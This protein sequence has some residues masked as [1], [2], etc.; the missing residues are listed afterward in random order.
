MPNGAVYVT[1]TRTETLH[2]NIGAAFTVTG[3]AFT[4]TPVVIT[5]RDADKDGDE[6][7]GTWATTV[8]AL[9]SGDASASAQFEQV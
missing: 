2:A 7:V 1:E 9:I 5:V 6:A 8:G 4:Q 3:H